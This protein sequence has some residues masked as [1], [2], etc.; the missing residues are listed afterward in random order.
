MKF[1]L[2]PLLMLSWF[3]LSQLNF[4]LVLKYAIRMIEGNQEVVKLIAKFGVAGLISVSVI[5]TNFS[6][7]A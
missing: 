4:S 1:W 3:N 6:N 5:P 2:Q 7:V